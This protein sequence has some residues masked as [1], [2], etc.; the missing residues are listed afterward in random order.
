MRTDDSAGIASAKELD[1]VRLKVD[2][3]N[4]TGVMVQTVPGKTGAVTKQTQLFPRN[5]Q[6]RAGDLDSLER[7]A[8]QRMFDSLTEIFSVSEGE[9]EQ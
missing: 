3:T 8:R 9:S 6:F 7:R 4:P 5:H 2:I 1:L